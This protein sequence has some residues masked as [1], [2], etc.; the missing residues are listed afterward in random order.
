MKDYLRFLY[1]YDD[2]KIMVLPVEP[3]V[4]RCS[5]SGARVREGERPEARPRYREKFGHREMSIE[6]A[7][8]VPP[9]RRHS[10]ASLFRECYQSENYPFF[11]T[12]GW[13]N[14]ARYSNYICSYG[15]C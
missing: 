9:I 6:Y 15:E 4:V 14:H 1:S 12:T 7:R 3:P 10:V 11:R 2:D 13:A 8:L 5:V